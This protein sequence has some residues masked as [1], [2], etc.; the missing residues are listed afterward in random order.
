MWTLGGLET[1]FFTFLLTLATYLYLFSNRLR[2]TLLTGLLFAL[3]VM[4]RPDGVLFLAATLAHLALGLGDDRPIAKKR[5]ILNGSLL[6]AAFSAVYVPYFIWRYTYYGYLLPNT[7]YAKVG[8]GT[9]AFIRGLRYVWI[10]FSTYGFVPVAA[11][12]LFFYARTQQPARQKN[13]FDRRISSYLF[14]QLAS[15]LFFIV[16][17]GGDQLVMKRFFAPVLPALYLLAFRGFGEFF[18][19]MNAE[20]NKRWAFGL[21]AGAAAAL[22]IVLLPSFAGRERTRVFKAEKPADSDRKLLGEWLKQNLHEDATIALIPAGITPY[23]SGLRTIDLV[24]LN[25]VRIAHTETPDFGKGEPGHEKHNSA[26]VLERRPDLIF[27]GACRIWP[28]KMT[29]DML[30][31]YYWIY[32]RLAPGVREMLQ[33]AEFKENYSPFAARI[34]AGYVHFYKRNDYSFPMAEPLAA[35]ASG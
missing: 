34:G 11:A 28:Q 23:Y 18:S 19:E 27:L 15:Y 12:A 25:D 20:R 8:G 7:F 35:S 21:A 10:F 1:V 33:L 31:N 32:G 22:L 9:D 3:L 30:R 26:Y 17:V 29:P 24:G 2:S 14:L 4:T 13:G 5:R 6:L 16:Y